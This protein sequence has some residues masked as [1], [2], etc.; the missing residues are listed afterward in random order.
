LKT[1]RSIV[2]CAWELTAQSTIRSLSAHRTDSPSP[3]S[4]VRVCTPVRIPIF[5]PEPIETSM[6]PA[7]GFVS[8]AGVSEQ[9]ANTK[10]SA[11]KVVQIRR[12][13]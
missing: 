5:G 2:V 8:A 3:S 12:I 1:C 7:A 9:D 13:A 6:V 10:G 4:S 11:S